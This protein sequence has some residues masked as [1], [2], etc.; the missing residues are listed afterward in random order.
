MR[1]LSAFDLVRVWEWGEDQHPID[2]SLALLHLAWPE[3]GR[4]TLAQ[5]PIG[6]RDG[7]LLQLRADTIGEALEVYVPCPVCADD[8]E[9]TVGASQ[10]LLRDPLAPRPE[11]YRLEAQGWVLE[12]RLP[13]SL[14]FQ[15]LLRVM[16]PEQARWR[17]LTR[18]VLSATAPDGHAAA[19]EA[20]PPEVLD[21]LAEAIAKEDP[22]ADVRFDLRCPACDHA[23][24][25]LLDI[26]AYFWEELEEV[27]R[28]LTDDVHA[29][30]QAYGW[31]EPQILSMS[32]AR[33]RWYLEK[34]E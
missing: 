19:A 22:Q 8:L 9:F 27:L 25:A 16:D 10:L 5:L 2:R 30:A 33:R 15:A 17:L 7:L 21:A 6:D 29:L 3:L 14:D 32:E 20:V 11:S 26:S 18:V 1:S 28:R 4:D 24:S 34:L 31:T 12:H 23:W 13:D